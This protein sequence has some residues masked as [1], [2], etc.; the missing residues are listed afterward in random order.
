MELKRMSRHLVF[1]ALTFV[2]GV[3]S[4]HTWL[5]API[6]QA[7]QTK[8]PITPPAFLAG[9]ERTEP[10]IREILVVIKKMD[11]RLENIEKSVTVK[12][13]TE[14]GEPSGRSRSR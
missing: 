12:K 4:A 10:V 11:S 8:P 6:A 7:Q 1:G 5:S 2:A 13:P 9:D 3:V 14:G